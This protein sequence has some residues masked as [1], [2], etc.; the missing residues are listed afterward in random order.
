MPLAICFMYCRINSDI[1]S[2][3]MYHGRALYEIP[4]VTFPR[5][6]GFCSAKQL[7]YLF[8]KTTFWTDNFFY[9]K[10]AATALETYSHSEVV[11]TV[12]VCTVAHSLRPQTRSN[13]LTRQLQQPLSAARCSSLL[14]HLNNGPGR[15]ATGTGDP[16]Q[17][18]TQKTRPGARL[19]ARP[20]RG[21]LPAGHSERPAANHSA[22]RAPR[23]T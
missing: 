4:S 12:A 22:P 1:M 2:Q 20:S 15:S 10:A 21:H 16:S 6:G 19:P 18:P 23:D 3:V 9:R 13:A 7:T 8:S 5:D 11:C 17:S 14:S